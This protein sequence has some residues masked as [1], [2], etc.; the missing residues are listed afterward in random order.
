MSPLIPTRTQWKRWSLPSKATYIG[1]WLCSLT[2]ML[3]VVFYLWPLSPGWSQPTNA[4]FQGKDFRLRFAVAGHSIIEQDLQD[5]PRAISCRGTIGVADVKFDLRIIPT[6]THGY[7]RSTPMP[8]IWYEAEH[9][10]IP[11]PD[12]LNRQGVVGQRL[13]FMLPTELRNFGGP[14]TKF[15][16]ELFVRD[17]WCPTGYDSFENGTVEIEIRP[18]ASAALGPRVFAG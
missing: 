9:F 15:L 12:L 5:A 1:V 10:D 4:P 17:I 13:R 7:S 3:A 11:N 18:P 6:I 2:I 16:A 14:S 8:Q